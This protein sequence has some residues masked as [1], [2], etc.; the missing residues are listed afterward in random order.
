M[1]MGYRSLNIRHGNGVSIVVRARESLVHGEGKQPTFFNMILGRCV[2]HLRNPEKVLSGLSN[3]SKD[4][5]YH[6]ERLYRILF[7]QEMYA[8]AYQNIYANEGNMTK[9]SDGQ[10]IDGM[11][12]QRIDALIT[13]LKDESYHPVPSRRVYIPKKNGKK[14]PLGI[15]SFDDK[16]VQEV[17]RMVLEAIY[18]SSFENT[19]HGFRPG[20][21]CHTALL[22]VQTR[23]TGVK[24]FVEGDIKGFFDNIDHD[25][26]IR[27]LQKRISDDRF[28]RLVRKFLNAGYLE[29]WQFHKTYSGTPQGGIISPIL[30]NIYLDEFDKFM[31][32]YAD[33]FNRGVERRRNSEYRKL[34]VQR[35]NLVKKL[36]SCVDE[37]EKVQ[38]VGQIK[39]IEKARNNV[40][41]GVAMDGD[42]RRLQYVR[43]ADDFLV[44]IIGSKEECKGV[45]ED[46][47]RYM[48]N[49]LMLK[50]SD[51]KTL[52]TNAQNP[53][54][55]LGYGI[56]IRKSNLSKRD[57]MGRLKRDYVGRVVL[58]VA[59]ETIRSKLVEL[60]TIKLT[61]V[62]GKEIWKPIARYSM[63]DSDDLEILDKFNSE[64]RGFYNYYSIAN[65]S[66]IINS[67]KYMME[68]S[69]Y[70][71]YCTKY[72]T[73][74]SKLLEKYRIGK[75]FCVR[76]IAKDGKEKVRVFYNEGFKRKTTARS[77]DCDTLPNNLKHLASTSLMDRLKAEKCEICGA[78]N[79]P[80]EMHQVRKLKDLKG[81]KFWEGLMIARRR[82]TIAA[83]HECH[84]K[85]HYGKLD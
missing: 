73:H 50:L 2:R 22:H 45:K 28:M 82:K 33:E 49:T 59:T 77:A 36:N 17:L 19:S 5:S 27:I 31:A 4:Q 30:A 41:Y 20:K 38:L 23:F 80:L 7:N 34:E 63:K 55:F 16:L 67:F 3:H 26:I 66:S 24:W 53:A 32:K 64:I 48:A 46:I 54:H 60:K 10:T 70:K 40:P 29:D 84:R 74:I 61:Y 78:E 72:R 56:Y 76:F 12:L 43:Y 71:T 75:D 13:A 25:V 18:E 47:R 11:S 37:A 68:Y 6:F 14:R 83:C 9:G 65:N 58:E 79:V 51:E 1:A 69:M 52:I 85:I 8:A 35:G 15:P 62:N 21:S 42:Y 39:A 44:G 81:K 57:S